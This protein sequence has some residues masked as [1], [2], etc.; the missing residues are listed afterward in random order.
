MMGVGQSN[1]RNY[2]TLYCGQGGKQDMLSSA[3]GGTW[4]DAVERLLQL[5]GMVMNRFP[6]TLACP[7]WWRVAWGSIERAARRSEMILIR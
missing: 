4:P 7:A 6:V 3:R 2:Y 5:A 1:T